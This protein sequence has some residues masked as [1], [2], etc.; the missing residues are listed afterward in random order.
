MEKLSRFPEEWT[1]SIEETGIDWH[2]RVDESSNGVVFARRIPGD[3]CVPTCEGAVDSVLFDTSA[4]AV[5]EDSE[6]DWDLLLSVAT[7]QVQKI[8][9]ILAE[10]T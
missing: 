5:L 2:S 4:V 8:R 1:G 3:C 10:N 9:R 7:A 6:P